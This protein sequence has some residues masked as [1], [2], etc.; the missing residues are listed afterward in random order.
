MFLPILF[1]Y[2]YCVRSWFGMGWDGPGAVED[3]STIFQKLY[4]YY[5]LA[6][7]VRDIIC[8]YGGVSIAEDVIIVSLLGFPGSIRSDWTGKCDVI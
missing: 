4:L 7:C 1:V 8:S 6:V 2:W 5:R 3:G